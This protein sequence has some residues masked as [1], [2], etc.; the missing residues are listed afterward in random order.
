M[1]YS[2]RRVT[3]LLACPGPQG[4]RVPARHPGLQ[5]GQCARSCAAPR[6]PSLLCSPLQGPQGDQAP[7]VEKEQR[8][9]WVRD[10]PGN[11]GPGVPP[12][13]IPSTG[14]WGESTSPQAMTHL[15]SSAAG[16]S[17]WPLSVEKV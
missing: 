16:R 11:Q 8:Q 3:E 7:P 12:A 10:P 2:I 17:R 9:G 15:L 5:A 13:T 1:C 6:A 4:Y 14:L